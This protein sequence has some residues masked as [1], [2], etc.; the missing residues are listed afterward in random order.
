VRRSLTAR[1]LEDALRAT[2]LAPR[3]SICSTSTA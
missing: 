3:S 2:L 1:Q